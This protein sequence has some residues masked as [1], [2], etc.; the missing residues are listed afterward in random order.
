MQQQVA[1][2]VIAGNGTPQSNPE[3]WNQVSP[4]N[5][6]AAVTA[7]TQIDQDVADSVVPKLFSDHLDAALL[8]AGKSVEYD[9]Y[10]GDDHQF[11][12]NRTAILAHMLSFY[13]LHL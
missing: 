12:R 11:T 9:T 7:A 13:R 1:Q 6:V 4:I 10:P 2:A 5:Y 3:F 8:A